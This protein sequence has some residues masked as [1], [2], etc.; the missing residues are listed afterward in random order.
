MAPCAATEKSG[1]I[2]TS[3]ATVVVLPEMPPVDLR[4]EEKV[5]PLSL[6]Q[7]SCPRIPLPKSYSIP[8]RLLFKVG[9]PPGCGQVRSKAGQFSKN[10]L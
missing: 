2:H 6:A 5:D 3:T 4:L 9:D 1:R 7:Y 10:I 8:V